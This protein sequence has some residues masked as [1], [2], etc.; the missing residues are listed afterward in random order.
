MEEDHIG[1]GSQ[2]G[3]AEVITDYLTFAQVLELS[4]VEEWQDESLNKWMMNCIQD[5]FKH[6]S[7]P[8]HYSLLESRETPERERTGTAREDNTRL[9]P[10]GTEKATQ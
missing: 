4:I 1:E 7:K 9:V 8:P 2:I 10:E 3:F 6:L 5:V